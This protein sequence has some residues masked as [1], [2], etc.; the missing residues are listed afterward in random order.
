L[1]SQDV[2]IVAATVNAVAAVANVFAASWNAYN[3]FRS[4]KLSRQV[5]QDQRDARDAADQAQQF[6]SAVLEPAFLYVE[7]MET[8]WLPIVAS[9]LAAF[10]PRKG[11]ASD[12]ETARRVRALERTLIDE[13]NKASHTLQ[14]GAKWWNPALLREIERAEESLHQTIAR[15]IQVRISVNASRHRGLLAGRDARAELLK[16][17]A[18]MLDLVHRYAREQRPAVAAATEK[19]LS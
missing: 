2:V 19:A 8:E 9:G 11:D 16:H 14:V 5:A 7:R 12:L 10:Q 4:A 13:W 17:S 6:R 18:A 3:G 15:M 1:I